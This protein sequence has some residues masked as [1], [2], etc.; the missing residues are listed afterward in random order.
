V[1]SSVSTAGHR[2]RGTY[3]VVAH[4]ALRVLCQ[5]YEEE[6]ADTSLKY[7]APFQRD[8]PIW[9]ARM[10]ALEGQQQLEDDPTVMHLTAYL[11]TLGAQYDLL[12]RHHC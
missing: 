4:K 5:T 1:L 7:F 8:R 3:Q 11:L 12:A 9:M 2:F 6:V 10:C